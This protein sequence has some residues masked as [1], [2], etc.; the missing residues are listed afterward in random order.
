MHIAPPLSLRPGHSA[1]AVALRTVSE[2]L[3]KA[4]SHLLEI[5]PGELMAEHR[6]ALT[7]DGAQGIE[8]E[9]F[10]YDT[11]PGGAGFA[12]QLPTRGEEL[13]ERAFHLMENC[14]ENCDAS[15]YRCLRS[16]KNKF[17]HSLL[18]RH[19]G[20]ELLGYLLTGRSSG[21]N[22]ARLDRSIAG[23]YHDL[24]RQGVDGVSFSESIPQQVG[25]RQLMAPILAEARSGGRFVIALSAPL[26]SD[27][28][29]DPALKVLC[30][31]GFDAELILKNELLVRGN[32]AAATR[33]ILRRIG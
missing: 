19:V 23:L 18:D 13:F 9:V 5:E 26:S 33:D 16:F 22:K 8:A 14:P 3:A 25:E 21:F 6:P 29:A 20:A 7:P 24:L 28:P 12:S 1:T 15:C 27:E 2:A 4:A 31:G 10:L 30:E 11:L 17:E 32:V